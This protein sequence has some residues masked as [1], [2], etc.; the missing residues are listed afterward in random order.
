MQC[1]RVKPYTPLKPSHIVAFVP[2]F[3][4]LIVYFIHVLMVFKRSLT[5]RGHWNLLHSVLLSG[6]L[7]LESTCL[8]FAKTSNLDAKK[9]F[10][11]KKNCINTRSIVVINES[12][13]LILN[14]AMQSVS[15]II[16]NISNHR[17]VILKTAVTTKPSIYQL[18][19]IFCKKF[20]HL[21][22]SQFLEKHFLMS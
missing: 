15:W 19:W 21:P 13:V 14:A 12:I 9:T 16:W 6:T 22:S 11:T 7:S 20:V 17:M 3:F 8:I 18:N 1:L 10:S 2:M 5:C 4:A